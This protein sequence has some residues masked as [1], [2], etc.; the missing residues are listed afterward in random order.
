MTLIRVIFTGSSTTL[1][2]LTSQHTSIPSTGATVGQSGCRKGAGVVIVTIIV[3]EIIT[4][5]VAVVI[6]VDVVIII[7]AVVV[8]AV[9]C[10]R[11]TGP[12]RL[13]RSIQDATRTR[14]ILIRSRSSRPVTSCSGCGGSGRR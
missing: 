3:V 10:T 1:A 7:I 8:V 11:I 4:I 13:N 14:P 6:G 9:I 5:V 12:H 2:R